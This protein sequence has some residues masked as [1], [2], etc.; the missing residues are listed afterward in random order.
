MAKP[1][2]REEIIDQAV[3][4]LEDLKR[5]P[6]FR[7]FGYLITIFYALADIRRGGV[8]GTLADYRRGKDDATE[9]LSGES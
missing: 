8:A 6:S 9:W 4:V 1:R 3:K 5:D 7:T 2:T